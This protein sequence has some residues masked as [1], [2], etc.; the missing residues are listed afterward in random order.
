MEREIYS[1]LMLG[2]PKPKRGNE[3]VGTFTN[4]QL[5]A[6]MIF[7]SYYMGMHMHIHVCVCVQPHLLNSESKLCE[8]LTLGR[9]IN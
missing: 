2:I 1:Y 4:L 9:P 5:R 7:F 6:V 8:S 3:S